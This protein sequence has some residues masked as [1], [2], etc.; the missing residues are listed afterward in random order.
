MDIFLLTLLRRK[1]IK[2]S[3][4]WRYNI[5]DK[6]ISV[7]KRRVKQQLPNSGNSQ[8]GSLML[9]TKTQRTTKPFALAN[10]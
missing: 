4:R 6:I 7:Y 3:C 1:R 9:L 10:R 5:F 8:N 2:P